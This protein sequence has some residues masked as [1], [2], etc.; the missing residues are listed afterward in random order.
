[1][2]SRNLTQDLNS[3]P[4]DNIILESS[5]THDI[6]EQLLVRRLEDFLTCDQSGGQRY[7]P[8]YR[9]RRIPKYR[10]LFKFLREMQR[11]Q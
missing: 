2:F 1:M 4:V 8:K 10:E 7:I 9:K 3:S 6:Q 11:Y 5:D